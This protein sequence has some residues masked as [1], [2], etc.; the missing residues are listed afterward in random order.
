MNRW[1][2]GE[3]AGVGGCL[4]VGWLLKGA[5]AHAARGHTVLDLTVIIYGGGG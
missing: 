5:T 1:G 3:G 4:S 2:G